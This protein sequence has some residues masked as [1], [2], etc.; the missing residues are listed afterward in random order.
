MS[1]EQVNTEENVQQEI[2][3]TYLLSTIS[4]TDK[5]DYDKFLE[6]LS[7]EHALIVL[8]SAANHGQLKGAYNLDEAELIAK[9]IR[10][11]TPSSAQNEPQT[12]EEAPKKAKSTAKKPK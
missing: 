2:P 1:Q 11:I 12:E 9:A 10:K 6:N 3:K 7:P 5:A 8:I 4:Y